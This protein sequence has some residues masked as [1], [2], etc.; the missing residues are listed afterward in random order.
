MALTQAV[1]MT[2]AL[3]AAGVPY[4]LLEHAQTQTAAA[5]ALALGLQPH[6][7]AKTIVVA[8]PAGNIRVVLPASERID[9]H[10]LREHLGAGKDVH[11]LDE[12]A[13]AAAYPEFELGAVPPLGGAAD[14]VVLDSRLA[15]LP[16]LVV[17]AGAHDRSLRVA[18]A[19]LRSLTSA[20]VADVCAE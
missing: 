10:K 7:V 18:T 16:A 6:E 15:E 8:A 13:L 17:E 20:T 11:L 1:V 19:D 3:D 5:E 9:M 14:A 12:P 4:E 2:D